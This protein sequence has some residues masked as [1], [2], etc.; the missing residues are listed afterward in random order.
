MNRYGQFKECVPLWPAQKTPGPLTA[1]ESESFIEVPED[2]IVRLANVND[3]ALYFFPAQTPQTTPSPLIIVCPGG[4]YEILAWELEG[5]EITDRINQAGFHAA[6]LKYRLPNN[7]QGAYMDSQRAIRVA[8]SKAQDWNIDPNR[9]AIM[10]FS[11][12]AHL[13][14]MA[15]TAANRPDSYSPV[16]DVDSISPLPNQAVLVYPAYLNDYTGNDTQQLAPEFQ[17]LKTIAPTLLLHNEEDTMYYIATQV[18]SKAMQQAGF[19][20][21]ARVWP[22]GGHGHGVRST[23]DVAE[24]PQVMFAW[25]KAKWQL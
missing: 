17:G 24:W 11:A 7:R 9:V 13:S 23:A 16:D 4:G 12:G 25:L 22:H 19:D 3:A 14:A 15:A 10:G 6:I 1:T 20:V 2:T 8:R 18:F 5:T 21:A